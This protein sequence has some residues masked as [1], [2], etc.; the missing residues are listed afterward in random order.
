[1]H[2]R[3]PGGEK[4]DTLQK[5]VVPV[6][7][8]DECKRLVGEELTVTPG[9]ICAGYDEGG[10][11]ACQVRPSG[12][13]PSGLRPNGLRP[14]GSTEQGAKIQCRFLIEWVSGNGKK[15]VKP[16]TNLFIT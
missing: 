7:P 6:I 4:A 13:R 16:I 15:K 3:F 14:S 2:N 1:M 11:D 9:Q 5:V 10:K 8:N 12:L